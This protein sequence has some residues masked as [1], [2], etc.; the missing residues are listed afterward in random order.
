MAENKIEDGNILH[1]FMK[2]KIAKALIVL[3][4]LL[5]FNLFFT[6]NFFVITVK[7]GHLFGSLIDIINRASPLMLLSM[8]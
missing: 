7:D 4:L 6:K 3:V 8:E 5:L 1:D 2:S